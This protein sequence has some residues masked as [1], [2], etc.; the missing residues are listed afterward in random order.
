MVTMELPEFYRIAIDRARRPEAGGNE[1]LLA[2]LVDA[3][4]V[5][6]MCTPNTA[7]NE[8]LRESKNYSC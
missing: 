3:L 6:I 1:R 5:V 7:S 2:H 8:Q 4:L